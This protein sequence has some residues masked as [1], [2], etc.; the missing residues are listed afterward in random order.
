M[1]ATLF[2]MAAAKPVLTGILPFPAHNA[3]YELQSESR[4]QRVYY[5][6]T[7]VFSDEEA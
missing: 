4:L 5:G 6:E 3:P 1:S 7:G 2:R